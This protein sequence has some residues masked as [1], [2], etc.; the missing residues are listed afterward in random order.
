M[1]SKNIFI[2]SCLL[3]LFFILLSSCS[4]SLSKIVLPEL[5]DG[6]YDSEFPYKNA[7]IELEE[8]T[9]SIRMINSMAFFKSYSFSQNT[10]L[11][12][13]DP[14][15]KHLKNY[16]ATETLFNETLGGTATVIFKK[17][18][19]V[20]LLTCAHI[21]DFPDTLIYYYSN[22]A[23][24]RTNYIS[25]I[26]IK[27]KQSISLPELENKNELTVLAIDSKKDL[28]L[29]GGNIHLDDYIKLHTFKYPLGKSK[30]LNW[31][32]F[33]YLFGYPL[34]NKMVTKGIVSPAKN[35]GENIFYVD[36]N[37]N[38]GF[39]GGI[40]LAI[41]DGIPNFELVGI[42]KSGSAK[43]DYYLKPQDG[44]DY[45]LANSHIP[46]TEEIYVDKNINLRYGIANIIPIESVLSFLETNSA[47][48]KK[49]G[50][51]IDNF[52]N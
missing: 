35:K 52:F 31:G 47:L 39:S 9:G 26:A 37:I 5:H 43:I 11:K 36:A 20:A 46:F 10:E 12:K 22:Q 33:V 44:K 4:S 25:G 2:C 51:T 19:S 15:F 3:G 17:N 27:T 49:N 28:A 1:A 38:K 45:P 40:V 41:K 42:V 32:A 21:I 30:S 14:R 23:G 34:N 24:E 18:G 6:E 13:N 29:L 16:A 8:I 7:S 48:L 50:Y